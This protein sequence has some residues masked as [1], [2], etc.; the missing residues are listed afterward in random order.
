MVGEIPKWRHR[1]F[2]WILLHEFMLRSSIK[3]NIVIAIVPAIAAFASTSLAD[4]AQ[5]GDFY[6]S[7]SASQYSLD[8]YGHAIY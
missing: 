5:R 3:H 4:E 6:S 2:S 1:D 7:C 8:Y